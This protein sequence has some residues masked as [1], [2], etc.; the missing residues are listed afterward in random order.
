MYHLRIFWRI[1]RVLQFVL[2]KQVL[3]HIHTCARWNQ[4][5]HTIDEI[6]YGRN[7]DKEEPEPENFW[8]LSCQFTTRTSRSSHWTYWSSKHI[9]QCIDGCWPGVGLWSRIG[10]LE[11]KPVILAILDHA[12]DRKALRCPRNR[13]ELRICRCWGSCS[14]EWT[15]RRCWSSRRPKFRKWTFEGG[16]A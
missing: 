2:F 8:I 10:S 12:K 5:S 13:N 1:N 7:R 6:H 16:G 14:S 4:R 15:G 11:G 9:G 3:E